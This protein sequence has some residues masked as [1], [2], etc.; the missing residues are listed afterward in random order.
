MIRVVQSGYIAHNALFV[1]VR[2]GKVLGV[3]RGLPPPDEL[4][5]YINNLVER[6]C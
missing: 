2:D 3:V 6:K 5:T 4:A 1:V